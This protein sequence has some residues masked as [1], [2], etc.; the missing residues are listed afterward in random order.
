MDRKTNTRPLHSKFN[1]SQMLSKGILTASLL[2]LLTPSFAQDTYDQ[3][4]AFG[5]SYADSGYNLVE[6]SG[7]G[8]SYPSLGHSPEQVAANFPYVAFP[9]WMQNQMGLEDSQMIN[10]AI[11]GSTTQPYTDLG[12]A[13]SGPYQMNAWGGRRFTERDLIV[14]SFGGN[15][16]LGPGGVI[17]ALAGVGPTGHDFDAAKATATAEQTVKTL[18]LDIKSFAAAGARNIVIGGFSDLSRLPAVDSVPHPHSLQVFGNIYYQRLQEELRPLALGGTRIFLLDETRIIDQM[19][20]HLEDYGFRSMAYAGANSA[21]SIVGS[22]GLHLTTRGY[23]MLAKYMSNVVMAP[24]D[25]SLLSRSSLMSSQSFGDSIVGRLDA[26]RGLASAQFGKPGTVSVYSLGGYTERNSSDD[27]FVSGSDYRDKSVAIGAEFQ[28]SP[29]LLAGLALKSGTGKDR[30]DS[31]AH[32]DSDSMLG[33]GYL[34]YDDSVWF[35]DVL[36]G[37]GRHNLELDRMG[38]VQHVE[39]STDAETFAA[40][41]RGGYLFNF[42]YILAGPF[43]GVEYQRSEVDGYRETGDPYLAFDVDEQIQ[44]SLIS[45]FGLQ[46]RAPFQLGDHLISTYINIAWRHQFEDAYS[47][48]STLQQSPLLPISTEVE[49]GESRDYGVIGGGLSVTLSS[50]LSWQFSGSSDFG[51]EGGGGYQLGTSLNYSF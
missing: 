23:E 3:L 32:L 26:Q 24:N 25:F 30:P 50:A 44:K 41:A 39:G 12:S 31:G 38:V 51:R 9:Y 16:G 46:I 40:I 15:D 7:G 20:N 22:D 47:F 29:T 1:K 5:D 35:G 42:G 17:Y 34:S 43:V 11:G 28:I 49:D 10:Y 8:A 18:S 21:P 14:L 6:L 4:F 48:T 13:L 2:A 19:S 45:S 36:I 33:T 37:Y 27:G